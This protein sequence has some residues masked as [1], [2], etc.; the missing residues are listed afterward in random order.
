MSYIDSNT[1]ETNQQVHTLWHSKECED[2]F[3]SKNQTYVQMNTSNIC[4]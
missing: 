4:C 2:S 1:Q 3:D